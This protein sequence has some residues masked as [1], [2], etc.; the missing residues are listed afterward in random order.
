[1]TTNPRR[2][3]VRLAAMTLAIALMAAC[4]S[5]DS[6]EPPPIVTTTTTPPA[7]TTLVPTT[8]TFPAAPTSATAPPT[9][10]GPTA[11]DLCALSPFPTEPVVVASNALTEIS[12]IAISRQHEGLVWAHNDSGDSARLHLI[13]G[14]TGADLGVWPLDGAFA[15]DWEDMAIHSAG[16][17]AHH[18]YVADF[19]DNF[20]FRPDIRIY[21]VAEPTDPTAPGPL[22]T[23]EFVFTYP[24]G[25]TD[26]ESFLV[27]PDSGDFVIVSK[28]WDD[29][30][31][32][33]Y[34]APADTAPATSTELERI[35]EVDLADRHPLATAADITADGRVIG[36][37][38]IDEVLLWD[39]PDGVDIGTAMAGEPCS[40]PTSPEPQG[41]AL[42]FLRRRVGLRDDQ[43]GDKPTRAPFLERVGGLTILVA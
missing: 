43:R 2:R 9:P 7:T 23:E 30:P 37:R 21:R 17:G 29:S 40:A 24:D 34:R 41:E 4:G 18:L 3:L 8:T 6:T 12:G 14:D 33:I 19:G 32:T 36:L 27:D 10:T 28:S 42:A 35:G 16:D 31:T 11:A 1:M 15:F 39:R 26:A 38:T 13:E 25:A 22:A 20:R 5:S